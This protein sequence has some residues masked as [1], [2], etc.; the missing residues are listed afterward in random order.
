MSSFFAGAEM[1]TFFTGP[2][3]CFLASSAFVNSPV[4][5]TTTSSVSGGQS[6][7]PG[8]RSLKTG[9]VWRSTV[10]WSVPKPASA[11]RLP[12]TE[13]YFRRCARVFGSV[14]SFTAKMSMSLSPIAARN[15]LR[16]IRPKP[17]MPTLIAITSPVGAVPPRALKLRV[18]PKLQVYS[19]AG[20]YLLYTFLLLAGLLVTSPYYLV[21][22]RR[23][24]PSLKNRF[25]LLDIPR[26]QGSIWVHAVSVG[27]VKAV[28][29]LVERLRAA[30]PGRPLVVST[31]TPAGQQLA[32]DSAGLAD[33]VF[34]FPFDLPG[35]IRRT[36]D[37]VD[38]ELVIIAETE[39][40]PNFLRE[41]R[42]RRIE[43]MMVNGRISDRS[44]PRYRLIRG[45]LKRVLDDYTVLGMQSE[46]DRERIEMIGA[47]SAKVTVFGNL[48]YDALAANQP[49]EPTLSGVLSQHQPLWIAAS[50]APGEEE[51]VLT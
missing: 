1:M 20:M 11:L 46:I 3:R 2:R 9:I 7:F 47:N 50:T 25:G 22:F 14:I 16:P 33:H 24:L 41:C 23:Y 12:R 21:R 30:Y 10:M 31:I 19:A 15:R 17:L 49:L 26:L 38:P 27:E 40:W 43:V 48:K 42:K 51:H 6:L 45:W 5:S 44:L 35:A 34:Y 37:R 29:K 18:T 36:L 28:Q 32:R 39:I 8:S 4:D 13:S